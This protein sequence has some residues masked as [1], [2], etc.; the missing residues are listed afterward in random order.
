M[1]FPDGRIP[2]YPRILSEDRASL[3]PERDRPAIVWRLDLDE[4]AEVEASHLERATIRV[5][6]AISYR[7]AQASVTSDRRLQ[8]LEAVGRRRSTLEAERGGISLDIAG[9]R[10]SRTGSGYVIDYEQTLPVERWN[11]QIS[12][13]T[14]IVTAHTLVDAGLGMVRTL[15]APRSD[16]LAELRHRAAGLGIE[17]PD[18][19]SYADLLRSL[20]NARSSHVAF[21][22]AAL[23]T[24]R[25][26]G[27]APVGAHPDERL[28]HGAI[29]DLYAHVTAPLRRLGDRHVNEILLS[30]HAD[31]TPPEWAVAAASDWLAGRMVEARAL[32]ASID[33][34]VIDHTEA[35]IL[36]SHVGETFDAIVVRARNGRV[37]IQIADP[38]VVADLD[39]EG[40][41]PG[42]RVVVRLQA[43][44][45]V[46][47]QVI[48][49][50]VTR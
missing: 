40:I 28:V 35:T 7:Q 19:T 27:Y 38:A 34:E 20:D 30:I 26:A 24:L 44:D 48:F 25:G 43:A 18:I 12:I 16:D 9:Q 3:L 33:R 22:Y 2:L 31:E 36:T 50:H 41:S 6:N 29:G 13:L 5:A 1:Y 46:T 49:S 10:V 4:S 17:W 11:A 14:G 39:A 15:P 21:K 37:R 42:E 32:Q 45:P 8:L 23:G 47:G